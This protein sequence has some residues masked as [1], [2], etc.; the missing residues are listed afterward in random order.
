M[1]RE[2]VDDV[3]ARLAAGRAERERRWR[4]SQRLGLLA[5]AVIL[6]AILVDDRELDWL[7]GVLMVAFLGLNV[8]ANVVRIRHD[9]AAMDR[10]A[11][12]SMWGLV[13]AW[14]GGSALATGYAAADREIPPNALMY[15]L[16]IVGLLVS[17]YGTHG[18]GGIEPIADETGPAGGEE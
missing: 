4:R 8:A 3:A 16:L 14:L 1:G 9:P 15:G 5:L 10:L 18:P 7:N 11:R 17:V 13:V 12:T 6:G 2:E